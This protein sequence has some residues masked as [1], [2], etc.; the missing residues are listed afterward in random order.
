M[1]SKI[2]AALAALAVSAAA[3]A[4]VL[5]YSGYLQD[6]AGK[7]VTTATTISFRFYPAPAGG[8]TVWEDVVTVTPGAD[9]WFSAVLGASAANPLDAADFAQPLWLAL[10]VS[11]DAQEML[12]RTQLGT[13][14]YAL[15]VAWAGVTGKPDVYPTD[16]ASVAGKPEAFPAAPVAWADVTNKPAS[17][18]SAWADVS[19]VPATFPTT[20]DQVAAKPATYPADPALFQRRVFTACGLGQSIRV[21]NPDGTVA[22]EPDNDTTYLAGSG[23]LLSGTTLLTDNAVVARK[24]A[25]A[26]NQTFDGGTL[27][28]D[29]TSNR[30][31]VNT[32]VPSSALEVVGAARADDFGFRAPKA[33]AFTVAGVNFTP[34]AGTTAV[35]YDPGG[36]VYLSGLTATTA[37]LFAPVQL[38]DGAT[39]NAFSCWYYDNHGSLNLGLTAQLRRRVPAATAVSTVATATATFAGALDA[40]QTASAPAFSH[41]YDSDSVYHLVVS[42]TAAT[43]STHRFYGCRIGYQAAGPAY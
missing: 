3:H 15:A 21:V 43:A 38:P 12:P 34:E 8:T 30:I 19:G 20:W 39:L 9:G 41:A 5:T 27:F 10:K 26:G 22:C 42:M 2:A 1:T 28:L 37:Q 25:G 35:Q 17:F 11:T 40:I 18:P 36:F 33:A 16:W 7:P 6:A 32:T 24:D 23:I 29:Y 31:G 13:A 14:P 4:G